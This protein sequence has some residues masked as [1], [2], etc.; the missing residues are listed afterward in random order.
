[1]TGYHAFMLVAT[2]FVMMMTV[3]ALA[4]FLRRH[5]PFQVRAN[6]MMRS[7]VAAAIV[8]PLYVLVGWSI[9][10]SEGKPDLRQP[11][12]PVLLEGRDHDAYV[13]WPSR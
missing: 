9:G 6:M 12:R 2:A 7:F 4:L 1:M 5:V 13:A 10:W 8:G 11:V 3:P